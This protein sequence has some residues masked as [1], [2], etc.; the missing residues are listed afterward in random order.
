MAITRRFIADAYN[1]VYRFDKM[2]E[3]YILIPA[4]N[5][6]KVIGKVINDL[7]RNGYDNI[8]VVNDGS[9]DNTKQEVLKYKNVTLLNH[10]INRGQGA[11][12]ATGMDYLSQ[13]EK[14]KYIVT[15]DA[16]GQH[17]IQ[18]IGKMRDVLEKN[19]ELDLVIGSRFIEKTNTN[20]PL[21]RKITL[22]MGTL[23]L[24]FIY[25]LKVSDAHNGLRVIRRNVIGKL[26]PRLDD[27]SHASE[28]MHEIKVNN[29]KF[30]EHPTNIAYS[31]YSLSKGQSSLNSI[32]IAAKTIIHKI[33]VFLF[34]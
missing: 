10:F 23:F 2:T 26:I 25:G 1:Y 11:S 18:D 3:V 4:Y 32:K 5:E 12:L 9:T 24:R 14:C 13:L 27:F 34:E 21:T 20:A 7:I 30:L 16:D 31:E 15:F 8:C 29:L 6:G 17:D 33:N 19:K 28:I 22:K